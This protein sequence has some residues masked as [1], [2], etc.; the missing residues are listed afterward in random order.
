M[1]RYGRSTGG[2]YLHTLSAVDIATGWWEGEAI[3]GQSQQASNKEWIG[4]AR[5]GLPEELPVRGGVSP[6]GAPSPTFAKLMPC[7]SWMGCKYW[8]ERA[9]VLD[10]GIDCPAA[11]CIDVPGTA[12]GH[13]SSTLDRWMDA[14]PQRRAAVNGTK[15]SAGAEAP[16]DLPVLLG[17]HLH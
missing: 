7:P 17:S 14:I 9:C 10:E 1:A 11:L 5:A 6:R 8:A 3:T 4:S 15:R 13:G 16:G 12:R 2:E